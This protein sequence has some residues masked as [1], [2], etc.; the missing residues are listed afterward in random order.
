MKKKKITNGL[1]YVMI[2]PLSFIVFSCCKC[3][4]ESTNI[5][6]IRI[7]NYHLSNVKTPHILYFNG[8]NKVDSIPLSVPESSVYSDSL[9]YLLS[10]NKAL[11]INFEW[12]VFLNDSTSH[13]IN[14]FV[15]LDSDG[16]CKDTYIQNYRVNGSFVEKNYVAIEN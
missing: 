11:D 15:S 12:R 3:P 10:S 2:M 4:Q 8:T 1:V 14:N 13:I 9:D 5:N 16:C 7:S 6:S